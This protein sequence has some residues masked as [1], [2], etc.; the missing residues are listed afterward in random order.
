M[1]H[2]AILLAS[3]SARR[4]QLLDQIGVRHRVVP[5]DIDETPIAGEPPAD[6]VTR[7]AAAKAQAVAGRQGSAPQCP[8]LAADTTV[9]LDGRLFGKPEGEDDCVDML[10]ALAGR[11]HEVFTALALWS[12][13]GLS[14][15]LNRSAVTFR[16]ISE[17][18][19]RRYWA[20]GEPAGKAGAY[21]IQGLGA[22][23]VARLEGSFS[24]V[25]GL[26]LFEA[27]ALLDAAGVSRWQRR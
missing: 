5:A 25:M 19:C 12:G 3:A 6:Y 17:Q 22:V 15:A 13:G 7:L 9:A 2:D 11:T 1:G 18:E 8:V 24:G 21:A 27:A 10:T 4:S 26:P 16:P 23:F 14:Q 20:S